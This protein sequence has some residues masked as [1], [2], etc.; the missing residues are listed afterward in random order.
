MTRRAHSASGGPGGTAQP[1]PCASGYMMWTFRKSAILACATCSGFPR[2]PEVDVMRLACLFVAA[3]ALLLAPVAAHAA[4]TLT[5]PPAKTKSAQ[6]KAAS[7]KKPAPAAEKTHAA[8]EGDAHAAPGRADR[9]RRARD[10][11]GRARDAVPELRRTREE[12][13]GGEPP[14]SADRRRAGRARQQAAR[15]LV[16]RCCST[17]AR[18]IRATIPKPA[19][20]AWSPTTVSASWRARARCAACAS[21]RPAC[22]RSSTTRTRCRRRCSRWRRCP[23]WRL[24]AKRRRRR[25]RTRTP[26]GAAAPALVCRAPDVG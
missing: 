1:C 21:R 11:R 20:G 6:K 22:R 12:G 16:R 19:S 18:S 25:S 24:P 3:C 7:K 13:D 8:D 15:S 17:C 9:Q 14:R 23:R 10:Q 4:R 26:T 5:L 2:R